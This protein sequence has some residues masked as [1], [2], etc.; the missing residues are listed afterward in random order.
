MFITESILIALLCFVADLQ[1][2]VFS[3]AY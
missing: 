1:R 2:L 3:G